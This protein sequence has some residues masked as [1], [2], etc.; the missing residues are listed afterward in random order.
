[1][2]KRQ[3][4]KSGRKLV[5]GAIAWA[6]LMT[7]LAGTANAGVVCTVPS[8]VTLDILPAGCDATLINGPVFY[9][10]VVN[11]DTGNIEFDTME[12]FSLNNSNTNTN[13]T[14]V[15]LFV[16]GVLTDTTTSTTQNVAAILQ[17]T[18]FQTNPGNTAYLPDTGTQSFNITHMIFP[19]PVGSLKLNLGDNNAGMPSET[20]TVTSS[21][22]TVGN[23]L[24][25][26]STFTIFTEF[27]GSNGF[28][29]ATDDFNGNSVG[30]GAVFQLQNFDPTSNP[31]LENLL[32]S[33]EPATSTLFIA[34]LAGLC[35]VRRKNFIRS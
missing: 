25:V 11:G 35:L 10:G 8:G 6:A 24:A 30:S 19:T 12:L 15:E 21:A 18:L 13:G 1:M 29:L 5:I 14:S 31:V 9:N 2:K 26:G 16:Q 32:L 34:A 28:T 27:S 7:C 22:T 4:Q 23:N 33:P 20:S 17:T 3:Q